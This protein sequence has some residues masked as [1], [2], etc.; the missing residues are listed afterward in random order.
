MFYRQ[1][2]RKTNRQLFKETIY[3][4]ET[5]TNENGE[6]EYYK[7]E[8]IN[9][10]NEKNIYYHLVKDRHTL[11]I[12]KSN[13]E[14]IDKMIEII[15]KYGE[16]KIPSRHEILN[17]KSSENKSINYNDFLKK[18]M[19]DLYVVFPD[20][21]TKEYIEQMLTNKTFILYDEINDTVRNLKYLRVLNDKPIEDIRKNQVIK[22]F[23]AKDGTP[24][25]F[26]EDFNSLGAIVFKNARNEYKK[27][28]INGQIATFGDPK[29]NFEDFN[30]YDQEKI[31]YY[32]NVYGIDESFE[33][34][35][36]IFPGTTLVNKDTKE[37]W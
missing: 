35:T 26:Y 15:E 10:I 20:K 1:T 4:I 37:L 16:G 5:I 27:L 25:A 28:A 6:K 24:K 12:N 7:K 32:K 23:N 36:F 22:K 21:F 14:V 17:G 29:F 30:S 9:I 31:N 3:S 33:F 18:Y 11:I 19:N 2:K 8:K 34:Y 13:P